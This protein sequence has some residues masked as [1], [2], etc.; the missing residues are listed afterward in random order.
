MLAIIRPDDWNW[1]LFFHVLLGMIAIGGVLTVVATSLAALRVAGQQ[2]TLLR[3]LA[4]RANALAVLPALVGLY[5]L[6]TILS[7]REFGDD[8]PTWLDT[9]WRITDA[10]IVVGGVLLTIVQYWV[11]RRARTGVTGGWPAAIASY[12]P[13]AVLAALGVVVFLMSGKP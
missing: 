13:L 6:G 3:V 4:F 12:L 8:S 10:T 5:V 2:V 9:S 7:D 11:A 1:L